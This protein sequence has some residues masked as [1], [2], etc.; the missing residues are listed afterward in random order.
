MIQE[1]EK[2]APAVTEG[3]DYIGTGLPHVGLRTY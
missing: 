2:E 3:P 1:K